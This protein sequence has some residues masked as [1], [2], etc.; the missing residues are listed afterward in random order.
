MARGFRMQESYT[1]QVVS[2]AQQLTSTE[3]ITEAAKVC[4]PCTSHSMHRHP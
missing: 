3:A 1:V 4:C 2:Q